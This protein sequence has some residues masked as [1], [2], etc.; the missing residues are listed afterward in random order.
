MPIARKTVRGSCRSGGSNDGGSDININL[1]KT[2]KKRSPTRM[3]LSKTMRKIVIKKTHGR[4]MEK[5]H[6][7]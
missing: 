6:C 2:T 7:I 5:T 3:L 1:V 4:S